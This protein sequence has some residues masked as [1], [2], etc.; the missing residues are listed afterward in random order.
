M[1]LKKKLTNKNSTTK[2]YLAFCKKLV[3]TWSLKLTLNLSISYKT[4]PAWGME[5]ENVKFYLNV[6]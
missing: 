1:K 3:P 4:T 5:G 2:D 6:T